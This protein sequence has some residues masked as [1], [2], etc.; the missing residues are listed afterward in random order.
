[1]LRADTVAMVLHFFAE[2]CSE[3]LMRDW[4]GSPEGSVFWLP[5]LTLL[6]NKTDPVDCPTH[7]STRYDLSSELYSGL[8][9]ATIKFLSR[10]CWCHPTNQQL[11]SVVLC[12]VI[13]Q[14]KTLHPNMT[15]LHGISGF[16]RRLV[17]QLLLESEKLFVFVKGNFPLHR[18]GIAVSGGAPYH[19]RFGV[20]HQ[21]QLLYLS[22][23]TTCADILKLL[24]GALLPLLGE[25]KAS[26]G[27]SSQNNRDFEKKGFWQV[28]IGLADQLSV[29]AGVT[30]KDKR[31]K[32]SKNAAAAASCSSNRSPFAK[33][34]RSS[35]V[36]DSSALVS[37]PQQWLQHE[38]CPGLVLPG[39]MALS[40]LLSII[41]EQ[42]RSLST[43]CVSLSLTQHNKTTAVKDVKDKPEKAEYLLSY[44][45][46][47]TPLQV[48]SQQG[49]LALLAQ[50][51]PLVYP[52]TLRY[53]IPDKLFIPDTV[54]AEWVKV[55]AGDDIYEDLDD[56]VQ[57]GG[58]SPGGV[59]GRSASLPPPSVPPHSLAAFGLFLR[60]P[61][62]SEVL[63]RDKKKA[64]CLLRLVLGVTDDGEGG[65]IFSS[66][67][68]S[69]LHTL[70]FQ[71]LRQLFD[72]TLLTTDDG[73]LLRR[74]TIDIGA[75]HLLLG[76]LSVF[77]HQSQDINLPGVQHE[78]RAFVGHY[79][80]SS[81][82]NAR[83]HAVQKTMDLPELKL[84][85]GVETR[86]SSEYAML[87]RLVCLRKAV[88]AEL[89]SSNSDIDSLSSTRWKLAGGIVEDMRPFAEATIE[90]CDML[91]PQHQ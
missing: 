42:G 33:K 66:P 61:G 36:T 78:S 22:T 46:L 82:A 5:L 53:S 88:A 41:Q 43:P 13:G 6:C 10:C 75:V 58:S 27:A 91:I 80:R 54:D 90:A 74:T 52:D 86:W 34:S 84:I 47:P 26:D 50:H 48:F 89:A 51:L 63:L 3:G 15:F 37:V 19:P 79:S 49:G 83:L 21:H 56:S 40:Q 39:Q 11:L 85:Q 64:Q 60:L 14:Q 73:V 77:T 68:A 69:S 9:S 72:S 4:L 35:T 2:V 8:E 65:D 12:D 1:M 7:P 55:E 25:S 76:C 31:V 57:A 62:Y 44:P 59:G 70:P 67:V 24:T 32:D 16:T 20:G 29:A 30:A 28:G 87:D 23:Q 71:V 81:T 17:L 18:S 38:S 45:G